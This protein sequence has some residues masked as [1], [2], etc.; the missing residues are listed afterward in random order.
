MPRVV[1]RKGRGPRL[2]ALKRWAKHAHT[3]MRQVNGYSK[4]GRYIH[5]KATPYINS[6]LSPAQ[7][8]MVHFGINHALSH[9]QKKGYGVSRVGGALRRAGR[10]KG[11]GVRRI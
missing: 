2:E 8:K 5:A 10:R 4:T 9:L 11:C 1:R 3:R 6:K 7:A